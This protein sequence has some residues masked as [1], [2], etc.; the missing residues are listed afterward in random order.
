MINNLDIIFGATG[1]FLEF[2]AP[3][4]APTSIVSSVFENADGDD[5]TAE[6][7]TTGSASA[8]SVSTTFDAASGAAQSDPH[9]LYIASTTGIEKGSRYL[10]EN[11]AGDSETIECVEVVSGVSIRSRLPLRNDYANADTLVGTTIS[12]AIDATWVA[13]KNNI[14]DP[15]PQPRYRWRIEYTAG[16]ETRVH[17]A[18]FDLVRQKGGTT[19]TGIDVDGAY[20]WL[21]WN[22]K[23]SVYDQEDR[24]ER[25]IAE[26]YRQVKLSLSMHGKAD[27]AMRNREAMED[28]VIHR[29]ALLVA[30]TDLDA[31]ERIEQNETK[32]WNNFVVAGQTD[33][34]ADGS[35]A[36]APSSPARVWRR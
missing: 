7:A 1:Q 4:G 16:G 19:V 2:D 12:H 13:D 5:A 3:E 20:P 27:E 21:D 8:S 17:Y 25:V 36:A 31:V 10:I 9:M 15:D 24:G 18:Y 14:S 11:A 26:A 29:A 28:L 34:D 6:S 33:S 35:G 23:L 32:S 22:S 30:G